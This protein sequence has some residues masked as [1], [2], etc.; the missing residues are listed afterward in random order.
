MKSITLNPELLRIEIAFPFSHGL[1][2]RTKA[3]PDCKF[4]W[5]NKVWYL[6]ASK[7][8]AGFAAQFAREYQFFIDDAVLSLSRT[9]KTIAY[10]TRAKLYP[11]QVEGLDFLHASGGRAILADSPGCGK[12]I[13]AIAYMEETRAN[14]VL[15]VCPAS[16]SYLWQD[17]LGRW[18]SGWSAIVIEGYSKPFDTDARVYICSYNVFTNR[19]HEF[20]ELQIDLAIMDECHYISNGEA[21]RSKAARSLKATNIIGLSGTPFLNRPKELWAIL[22]LLQPGIWNNFWKFGH[23]YCGAVKGVFGWSFDGA[24]NLA[25]LKEKLEYVMLRRTK[26]QVLKDLPE[27]QINNLPYLSTNKS[28][29]RTYKEAYEV[30]KQASNVPTRARILGMRKAIGL[31]KVEPAL[32]LANDLLG[33]GGKIVL[34]AIHKDVVALLEEGMKD[35]GTIKIVGDTP[36]KERNDLVSKFQYDP[37]TRVAIISEAGGEGINLFAASNLIFVEREWNPGKEMQIVGRCIT[38]SSMVHYVH[39]VIGGTSEMG[40]T[41]IKDIVVGDKVLSHC[42]NFKSVYEINS[43]EHRGLFT[44]IDYSGWFEP[45]RTTHDHKFLV[46]RKNETELVWDK[47]YTLLPGDFLV[48]PKVLSQQEELKV[49]EFESKWRVHVNPAKSNVCLLD[50]CNITPEARGLCRVH[51]REWLLGGTTY[52]TEKRRSGNYIRMPDVVELTDDLLYMM[53]WYLAEGWV[54]KKRGDSKV[55]AVCGHE[56]EL[57]I[58]QRISDTV[59]KIEL[60]SSIYHSKSSKGI[61]LRIFNTEIANW[62]LDWF[63]TGSRNKHIPEILMGLPVRQASIL[64]NAYIEGDGYE[65]G[66]RVEWCSVSKTLSYQMCL[67]ATKCGYTP[68]MA[69]NKQGDYIG[70][71]TRGNQQL[72]DTFVYHKVLKVKTEFGKEMVYDLSVEDDHSFVVGFSTVHNC[73]RIGQQ[74]ACQVYYIIAKNTIDERIHK[75]INDKKEILKQIYTFE[76][77]PINDLLDIS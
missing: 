2:D 42:G 77:I 60:H 44:S 22:N 53:G 17:M 61:E 74:N 59:G 30:A 49:I 4:D 1:K 3:I 71:Y 21:K 26:D 15:V 66:N 55:L 57:P 38:D 14:K 46:Q 9:S 47:A 32:E 48:L 56:K 35:F 6:P 19:I 45:I 8:H 36:Q 39:P 34:F 41:S 50:G 28:L 73:H 31:M 25:E 69:K 62:F 13:Q 27:L 75:I 7:L 52:P 20:N 51:Y 33:D 58:L 72:D 10:K 65:R 37:N 43:H 12:S 5:D 54:A 64:L 70:A 40:I 16:V 24:S 18:L 68:T 63:G 29:I 23:K 76:N 11:F 67:L